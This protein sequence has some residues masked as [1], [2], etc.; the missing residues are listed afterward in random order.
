MY[1]III[2]CFWALGL[3]LS[4]IIKGPSEKTYYFDCAHGVH[5]GSVV[6]DALEGRSL[7]SVRQA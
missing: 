1:S 6:Q 2:L 4:I 7:L 5:F 3:I